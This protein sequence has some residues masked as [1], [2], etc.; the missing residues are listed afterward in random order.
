MKSTISNCSKNDISPLKISYNVFRSYLST[1]QLFPDPPT[2]SPST[3]LCVYFYPYQDKFVL[4][5]YSW[6]C[7]LLVEHGQLSSGFTLRE[8]WPSIF[9]RLTTASIY[10]TRNRISCST[11]LSMLEFGLAWVHT[12]L[13]HAVPTMLLVQMCDYPAMHR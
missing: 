2:P 3:Q 10:T 1:F 11:P 5:K 8:N 12:A 4:L 13:V 9:P 6:T 7:G